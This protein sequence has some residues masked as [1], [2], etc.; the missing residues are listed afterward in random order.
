MAGKRRETERQ[1]GARFALLAFFLL[2]CVKFINQVSPGALKDSI[3]RDLSLSDFQTTLPA[4]SCSLSNVVFGPVFGWLV[5]RKDS[6]RKVI[7]LFSIALWS[8]GVF[9]SGFA[10]N[11][12][13]LIIMRSLFG[14]GEIGFSVVMTVVIADYYPTRDR[15]AVYTILTVPMLLGSAIGFGLGGILEALWSWRGAFIVCASLGVALMIPIFRCNFPEQGCADYDDVEV[16]RTEGF[17]RGIW[18]ICTNGHF[19]LSQLGCAA[20]MFHLGVGSEWIIPL[21]SR[22]TN[23]SATQANLWI[24]AFLV[25][26]GSSGVVLGTK[27]IQYCAT[28]LKHATLV[29]PT[30]FCLA[31]AGFSALFLYFLGCGSFSAGA[32]FGFLSQLCCTTFKAP[33]LMMSINVVPVH[34]RARAQGIATLIEGSLGIV[35]ASPIVGAISDM[36][37]SLLIAMQLLWISALVACTFW[38]TELLFLP[39]LDEVLFKDELKQEKA[40]RGTV[41]HSSMS[42]ILFG[43]RDLSL[44]STEEAAKDYGAVNSTI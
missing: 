20:M 4:L 3:K 5:D 40:H 15:I 19:M 8:L 30:L 12:L 27:V 22:H 35:I 14:I 36:T 29:V 37:G 17:W 16:A 44:T 33:I 41:C 43:D 6:N 13:Q 9:C 1:F 31:N 18:S 39:S 34:L 42:S 28:R 24:A 38:S 2:N 7:M 25:M 23:L 26:G 32:P 11:L 10:H 21:I